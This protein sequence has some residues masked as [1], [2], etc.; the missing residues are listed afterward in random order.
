MAGYILKYPI[1]FEK[2]V[3][4]EEVGYAETKEWVFIKESWADVIVKSGGMDYGEYGN[5]SFTN[6]EFVI[7]Y[8]DAIDYDCRIKYS[9]QIYSIQHIEPI[10]RKHWMKIRSQAW[11][12]DK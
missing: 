2:Y 12:D 8:D 7:R 10:D 6:V 3:N 11:T 5:T 9:G 1:Y 4:T